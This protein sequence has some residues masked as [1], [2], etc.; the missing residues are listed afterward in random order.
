MSGLKLI[1]TWN[2]SQ[3]LSP[4]FIVTSVKSGTRR[5]DTLKLNRIFC[6]LILSLQS[7]A[8]LSKP[9]NVTFTLLL[10]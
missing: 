3:H 5:K 4:L 6:P 9:E 7:L 1:K 2:L 8:K 10:P